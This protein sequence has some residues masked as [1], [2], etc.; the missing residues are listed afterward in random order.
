MQNHPLPVPAL[1]AIL[2]FGLIALIL[3]LLT[4]QKALKKCAPTSRTMEPGRV[5]LTVIP[6]FGLV[7]H[8]IVVMNVAKSL[9]NE[10]AR[11]GIPCPEPAPGQPIGLASCVCNCCIFIPL[12]G[13]IAGIAGLVLWAVYWVKIA[14]YSRALDVDLATNSVLP[15]S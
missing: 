2:C 13:G 1:L 8:F 15:T 3:Y 11:L 6:L 4:L 10:F 9:G 14:K 5:W 12:L 7:W